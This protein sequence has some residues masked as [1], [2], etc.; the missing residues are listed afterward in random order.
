MV[1]YHPRKVDVLWVRWI[2]H[3]TNARAAGL[4]QDSSFILS[5]NV[6]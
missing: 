3:D 4:A 5:S 6:S 2:E 1:D